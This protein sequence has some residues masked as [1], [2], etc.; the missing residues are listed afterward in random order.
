MGV[1]MTDEE[2]IQAIIELEAECGR[3]ETRDD[4][5]TSWNAM[6][7]GQRREVMAF[8]KILCSRTLH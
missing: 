3:L 4:A 1:L 2:R 8:H 6:D 7:T 5:R